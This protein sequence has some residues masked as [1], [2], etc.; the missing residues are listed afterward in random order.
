M[1][2]DDSDGELP[3]HMPDLKSRSCDGD[4]SSDEE[5]D[6][7]YDPVIGISMFPADSDE[8]INTNTIIAGRSA[9][10]FT[11]VDDQ[12]ESNIQK[13]HSCDWAIRC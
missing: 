11:V 9:A 3:S 10:D 7:G 13:N 6:P 4:I 12:I 5:D 2:S 8:P 1:D